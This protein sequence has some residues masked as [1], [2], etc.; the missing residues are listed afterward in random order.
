MRALA[1][2]GE[3]RSCLSV[4]LIDVG[5]QGHTVPSSCTPREEHRA[6][7]SDAL[8]H[9]AADT[10]GQS[11]AT[12]S[13]TAADSSSLFKTYEKNTHTHTHFVCVYF[14]D[15]ATTATASATASA[16][17]LQPLLLPACVT[18]VMCIL[19]SSDP[20]DGDVRKDNPGAFHVGMMKAP[21][22]DPV[23]T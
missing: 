13:K 19:C 3:V 10:F 2:A 4:C 22:A 17:V 15:V 14:T 8:Q 20:V 18:A 12:H 5:C 1:P 9:R 16:L 7:V 23:C 11:R 21:G 6:A